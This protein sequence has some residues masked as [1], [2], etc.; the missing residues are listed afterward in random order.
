[1]SCFYFIIGVE[2]IIEWNVLCFSRFNLNF[3]IFFD[4]MSSIFLF[5]V[6]FISFCVFLFS[7]RYINNDLFY[8][9]F[10]ILIILFIFSIY[11]LILSPNL[12]RLL[13]GWDG[14][15]I[16]SY[17]LVIFY[18]RD[19]SYNAG[20]LTAITNR[21][22][23][24]GILFSISLILNYGDWSFVYLTYTNTNISYFL[25]LIIVISTC[26]KRAQIPFSAWLPAAM[27][28][29][30]P[31]SA[32]VHSST[33]VTAGVYLLVRFEFI[34]SSRRV[35][36]LLI[37]VGLITIFISGVS[38]V[39][40]CDIKKIIAL[41]TLSQLGVMMVTI[42]INIYILS[43]FHLLA[44]AFFKAM[45]F[46][47][48]GSVIHNINDYQDRRKIGFSLYSLPVIYSVI[49]I[50]KLRLCGL[51]FIRG[52]YSKH[53]IFEYML[54]S[55]ENGLYF[56]IFVLSM[57]L[58]LLYSLK[59]L[60]NL[61]L[62]FKQ[63]YVQYYQNEKDVYVLTSVLLLLPLAITIG[64]KLSWDFINPRFL[65]VPVWIK[66][67]RLVIII[68]AVAIVYVLEKFSRDCK[69]VFMTWIFSLIY[70]LPF[71]Y[72]VSLSSKVVN[73]SSTNNKNSELSWTE[74]ILYSKGLKFFSSSKFG[75]Y[76]SAYLQGSLNRSLLTITLIILLLI[77][78]N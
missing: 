60:L 70:F 6:S 62:K 5:V 41:S 23:D 11:L 45:L 44:H 69:L 75:H 36:T 49:F 72:N 1:M 39:F 55:S 18:N 16:T 73:Y 42:S 76:S 15:G 37:W 27:A 54:I 8:N 40:E 3:I 10:I 66:L 50:S 46:L 21:L 48:A 14:L 58:T 13:L 64:R 77:L 30:T 33:L 57:L 19:K 7:Y 17:L 52:F 20:I 31:V 71:R 9:R 25:V 4:F 68:F 2:L 67:L 59:F 53:L 35:I 56:V 78:N 65:W 12:I 34:L 32:L 47:C 63:F 28:A 24:I 74:Y 22:G 26:T 38:A 29:P 61:G 51:P 43:Y